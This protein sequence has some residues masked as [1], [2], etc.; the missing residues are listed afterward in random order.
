[1]ESMSIL[2]IRE[3]PF[4]SACH[5]LVHLQCLLIV[6]V[7]MCGVGW[8]VC[9]AFCVR[10]YFMHRGVATL[11]FKNEDHSIVR[12]KS[13][14]LMNTKDLPLNLPSSLVRE[15]ISSISVVQEQ[16]ISAVPRFT[17]ACYFG[18]IALCLLICSCSC[19]ISRMCSI[20][21]LCSHSVP[22][23]I[24]HASKASLLVFLSETSRNA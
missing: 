12:G 21:A 19:V 18:V 10:G 24:N 8:N 9:K 22:E 17:N 23:R 11:P 7:L 14:T 15:M 2:L 5:L 3:R 6:Q 13:S 16:A 1:M 4:W 20:R